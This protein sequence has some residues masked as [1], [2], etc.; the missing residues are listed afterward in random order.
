MIKNI[1]SIAI[2]VFLITSLS[3]VWIQKENKEKEL[4]VVNGKVYELLSKEV[5]VVEV[6][7]IVTEFKEGKTIYV[8]VEVPVEVFIPTEIDTMEVL[9]DFYSTRLYTDT[10]KVENLGYLTIVDTISQNKIIGRSFKANLLERTITETI[11][12]KELPRL[13]I[14]TG[15]TA[16]NNMQL[17]ATIGI[18]TKRRTHLGLD[19]G[20]HLDDVLLSP[21]VGVRYLWQIR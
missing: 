12:V 18:T 3:Y 19:V 2:I 8:E 20:V 9:Q 13:Q 5:E 1:I 10:L 6:E 21:Y 15:I 17:G 16:S 7:K 14:W 11:T 4:I